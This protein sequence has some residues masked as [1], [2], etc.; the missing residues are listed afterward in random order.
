M[1]IASRRPARRHRRPTSVARPSGS[2]PPRV[3]RAG[4]EH[5]G[6]VAVDCAQARSKWM[7]ADSSGKILTPPTPVEPTRRGLDDF[8]A[9]IRRAMTDP[10]L[11]DLVVAVERAGHSRAPVQRAAVAAGLEARIVHPLASGQFRRPA[12]PGTTTDDTDLLAI[13]RA[14]GNG[15][16]LVEPTLDEVHLQL[17]LPAR[18]R[19]DLVRQDADL[20]DPIPAELDARLP[21]LA[22][23]VGD[24][25]DHEPAL[26]RA[27]HLGSPA[28]VLARGL[29]GLAALLRAEHVRHHRRSPAKILAWAE[30]APEPSDGTGIP[31]R[32]FAQPE[33]ERRA[34]LRAIRE[35]EAERAGLLAKA[36]Y[37][38]LL[39][40]P[41]IHV[42]SAAE[43]AAAMGPIAHSPG[44][45][46][47]TGRAGLFPSRYQSDATDRAGPLV[48]RGNRAL[49]YVIP[50]IA[51]DL[52]RCNDHFRGPGE[53]W[54]AAG[55]SRRAAVVRAAQRSGPIADRMVAGRQVYRHP[56][57]RGRHYILIKLSAFYIEHETPLEPVSRGLRAAADGMPPS[58]STAAA[59]S[60]ASGSPPA[61]DAGATESASAPRAERPTATTAARPTSSNG[62]RTGPRP[63]SAIR[64]EVFLRPGVR[65]IGSSASGET[66]PT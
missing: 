45:R 58:E 49:R 26:V 66:D 10:H 37:L 5:F 44:D 13:G 18:H 20:R 46:A 59:A 48:R 34:R 3:Q 65:M 23:A 35:P 63:L 50:P 32:I 8:A 39:S 27:R 4:P 21:G 17:R 56:S 6:I 7:L 14:A 47:I 55:V 62:R 42:A 36:P 2:I 51:E 25:F 15:L 53:A 30:R 31:R 16:G 22:A 29:G 40:F 12:D 28:E 1:A 38:R 61:A 60:L 33:D 43:F 52:R 9:A 24:S 41:G 19:R 64:P 11:A 57:R 54:R